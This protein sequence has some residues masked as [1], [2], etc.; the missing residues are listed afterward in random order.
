MTSAELPMA[1]GRDV[2]FISPTL[3]YGGLSVI[4]AGETSK[5]PNKN[6]EFPL[7]LRSYPG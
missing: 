7:P 6:L 5:S 4:A 2:S 1:E 3:P